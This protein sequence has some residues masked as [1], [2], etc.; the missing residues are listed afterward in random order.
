MAPP[1]MLPIAVAEQFLKNPMPGVIDGYTS[2][3]PE[4]ATVLAKHKRD[5]YLDGL[6]TL[7][8]SAAEALANYKGTLYLNGLTTLSDAAA[9][10]LAKHEAHTFGG[11]SF[12]LVLN[13]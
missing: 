9:E 5:L 8:G 3:D 12:R 11:T 7:S 6:T 4:A 13:R 2:I 1:S 10:A